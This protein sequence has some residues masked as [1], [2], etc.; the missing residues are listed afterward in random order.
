MNDDGQL[1]VGD[2]TALIAYVLSGDSTG[3]NV[4]NADV[5]Q[6]SGITV[7]DVTRLISMVLAQ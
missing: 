4:A 2:V 6:D 7:A 3:L 1:S 5:N